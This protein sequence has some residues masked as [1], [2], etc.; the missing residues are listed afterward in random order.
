MPVVSTLITQNAAVAAATLTA[1]AGAVAGSGPGSAAS[2]RFGASEV[3]E[4]T[5]LLRWSV[6]VRDVDVRQRPVS[7]RNHH[8]IDRGQAAAAG[9]DGYCRMWELSCPALSELVA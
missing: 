5:D 1:R 6:E 2:G 7:R 4:V 3:G 9:P 8:D